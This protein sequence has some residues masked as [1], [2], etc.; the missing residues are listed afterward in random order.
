MKHNTSPLQKYCLPALAAAV[1][2]VAL[3]GCGGGGGGGSTA[4]LPAPTIN[5]GPNPSPNPAPP[6]TSVSAPAL[7]NF[8]ATLQED[9]ATINA[10][11]TVNYTLTLANTSLTT[12]TIV[13]TS[14]SGHTV[15]KA[16]LRVTDSS[17]TVVYPVSRPGLQRA[18]DVPAPPPPPSNDTTVTLV[19]GQQL[20]SLSRSVAAFSAKGTYQA[21]ATFT[22][23]G[24]PS[25]TPQ[26]VTLP[27]LTVTVQ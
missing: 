17:G 27:P 12:A 16:T 9:N 3:P 22:V 6:A 13:A 20:P 25:D 4:S 21:V 14:E 10:G 18:Q 1:L 15:P 5:P 8:T 24:S 26:T 23:A 7:N 19:S 11:G 2:L